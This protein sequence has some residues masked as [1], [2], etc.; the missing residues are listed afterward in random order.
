MS[1]VNYG[2]LAVDAYFDLTQKDFD[3]SKLGLAEFLQSNGVDTT[4]DVLRRFNT[5]LNE[6]KYYVHKHAG[7]EIAE[8]VAEGI[9][10]V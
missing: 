10:E 8:L 4:P 1:E 5:A 3:Y 7:D 2:E 6:I 9:V